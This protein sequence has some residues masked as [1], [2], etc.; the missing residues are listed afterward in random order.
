M[1]STD[2]MRLLAAPAQNA[3]LPYMFVNSAVLHKKVIFIYQRE[4]S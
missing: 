3:K 4:L 1:W 2:A